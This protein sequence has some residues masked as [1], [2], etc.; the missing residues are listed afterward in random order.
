MNDLERFEN[1]IAKML[2][3]DYYNLTD[4]EIIEIVEKV[5]EAMQ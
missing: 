1:D 4:N 2:E 3:N 5:L